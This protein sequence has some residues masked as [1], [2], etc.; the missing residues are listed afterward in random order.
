MLRDNINQ[1][2]NDLAEYKDVQIMAVTKTVPYE[3]VNQAIDEGICLLGENRVQEL[4]EKYPY[5]KKDGIKIHFIGHLQTNKVKYI[6]DKVDMIES[7]DSVDLAVKIDR[8]AT[9]HSKVMP[10]LLQVNI[11]NESSKYGFSIDE[12]DDV[13]ARISELNNIVIQGFMCI[14][15]PTNNVNEFKKMQTLFV[16][17]KYEFLSMGMSNDY[18]VA[19]KYNA[20]IVRL[21]S[22]LFGKRA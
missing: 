2:K 14:G 10:I 15:S 21:G 6:I 1:I 9:L 16:K 11:S 7:V 13:I 17:N 20:N 22:V 4:L 5:Y 8:Y 3:I 19:V 12:I 18:M